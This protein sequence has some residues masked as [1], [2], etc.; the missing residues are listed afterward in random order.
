MLP[1]VSEIVFNKQLVLDYKL[2]TKGLD[3]EGGKGKSKV[4][5]CPCQYSRLLQHEGKK[6]WSKSCE[7]LLH[8]C[9]GEFT[10]WFPNNRQS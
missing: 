1:R 8:S 3:S 9:T 4:C 10:S 5:N 6:N 2:Q 7:L